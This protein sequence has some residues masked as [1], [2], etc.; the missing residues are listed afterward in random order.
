M[1]RR[2]ERNWNPAF[3]TSKYDPHP[4]I[5]THRHWIRGFGRNLLR[6]LSKLAVFAG[7]RS[8]RSYSCRAFNA[9]SPSNSV[10]GPTVA[11]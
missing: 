5:A 2:S 10:Y 4:A 6:T 7:L 8:I 11:G 3:S 1:C 9:I